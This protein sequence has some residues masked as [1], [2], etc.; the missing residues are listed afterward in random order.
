MSC[1]QGDGQK[2]TVISEKKDKIKHALGPDDGTDGMIY[3]LEC[4][5]CHHQ[6][7]FGVITVEGKSLAGP[8]EARSVFCMDGEDKWKWLG[9][10]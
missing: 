8:I 10:C 2:I 9:C 6:F 7:K 4:D 3:T 1:G 5:I